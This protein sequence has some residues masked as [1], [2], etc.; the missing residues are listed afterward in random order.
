MKV[1]KKTGWF[2]V[3]GFINVVIYFVEMHIVFGQRLPIGKAN[4]G[5][6]VLDA[7]LNVGGAFLNVLSGLAQLIFLYKAIIVGVIGFILFIPVNIKLI[8]PRF[9]NENKRMLLGLLAAISIVLV[10]HLGFHLWEYVE[11]YY[12]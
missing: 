10:F 6:E 12:F 9:K 7:F 2:F 1:I 8:R 5:F 4:S 3:Y 11:C